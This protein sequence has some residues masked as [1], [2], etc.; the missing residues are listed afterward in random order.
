LALALHITSGVVDDV[1]EVESHFPD[2]EVTACIRKVFLRATVPSTER[3][4]TVV[5]PLRLGR[6]PDGRETRR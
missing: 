5:Y 4:L 1:N 2:T 3:E 6:A